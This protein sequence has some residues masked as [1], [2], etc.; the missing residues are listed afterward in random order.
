MD[1]A[2]WLRGLGLERYAQAFR[3]NDIDAEVLSRLRADDLIAIGVSSVGHRRRLLDA[4]TALSAGP[5]PASEEASVFEP[6]PGPVA[7]RAPEAERRQLTVMFVDLVG[8]T[9]ISRRLDPEAMG[10]IVR[11]Y[12]N[13]VAGE[14]GRFEGHVA[15]F[16]G[17]GVLAYFGWPRA[18]EDEAERAV[19]A[20]L[21]V[22]NA[23]AHLETPEGQA[24]AA[25]VGIATGLV[26]VGDLFD[27]A[28]AQENAA[29]GPTLALAARLQALA[30]PGS[31]VIAPG[32]RL[33]VGGLFD[34]ADLGT[35][36]VKGFEKAVRAWRVLNESPAESRF[37]ALH[38]KSL[39]PLVGREHEIGLLLER[40]E[41]A[42]D[43]EGQVVL[44]SGEPGLG[45]SRI[46][47]ALR[48]R[49]ESEAYT[50][51]SHFCSPFHVNSALYPVIA[52]LDRAAR[53]ERDDPPE[54]RLDKLEALLAQ[55][56]KSAREVAPLVAA[57]LSFPLSDRYPPLNLTP[58]AQKQRT[59]EVLVDQLAG[60]ASRQPVLAIYEDVHW[61]DPSTLDLLDLVVERVQRLRVL[62]IITFRPEFVPPWT[63]H[64]HVTSLVL[65]RLTR[66]QG[67]SMIEAVTGGKALPAEVL[68]QIVTKT[69]G[70]PL[71][72]EELTKT[73][74][75]SGPLQEAGDRYTLNGSLSYLAVPTTLHDSLLARLDRLGAAK[76][77]AQL[78]AALGREFSHELLAA[79]SPLGHAEL[80]EALAQLT[81]A[82]LLFRR[83][84]PPDATYTFKHALV[85]DA[86]YAGLLKSR[87]RQIHSRIAQ[88]LKDEFSE[89]V[90]AAPEL[91]AHHYGE[92]GLTEFAVQYWEQAGTRAL[93]RSAIIEAVAHYRTGLALFEGL[94]EGVRSERE[95]PIQIGL[96]S[97]LASAKGYANPE[98]GAAY[99]RARELCLE[100][101]EK[102]R[103][104][105]VLYG[106][107]SF[108]LVA[109]RY[110]KGKQI[111]NQFVELAKQH[112]E[113]GPLV[114]AYSALGSTFA[115]MGSWPDG[116]ENLEKCIT[117]YDPES[118]A[119]L[120]F[121]CAE[122]PCVQANLCSALCLWN[123]G[124]PDQALKVMDRA[125]NLA[126]RLQHANSKGYA[127]SVLPMLCCF[128][129]NPIETSVAAEACIKFCSETRLPGWA[130]F[131]KVWR[132]WALSHL[133]HAVEGVAELQ[134]GM[135]GWYATGGK[136]ISSGFF[137]ALGDA[138][139]MAGNYDEA[140]RAIESGLRFTE[141]HAESFR[142]AELHRL[143]GLILLNQ[144]D[145]N[146]TQTEEHFSRALGV[147][148]NQ[149]SRS[150]EL[151]ISTDLA[152]LWQR[153]GKT[154]QARELLAPIYNWFTEGFNTPA[155]KSARALLD[156]L[157]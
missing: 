64:S 139:R 126:E 62:I 45:K 145:K 127:L 77:T 154:K 33:L 82:G 107:W 113:S 27:E 133:G 6:A 14:V 50:P 151:R 90:A 87:R 104:F 5:K 85:R 11:A 141:G 89:R 8:S 103:L 43:G 78:G 96:G 72:I 53:F 9:E 157:D 26:V 102:Q 57:L 116:N 48:E 21:A 79:V 58:E 19:R 20:G 120:K 42:R 55:A 132:G 108:D 142:E 71:F 94:P 75:E 119:N 86:A 73:L 16:W 117:L 25:R 122:D 147:A 131:A 110:I 65:G 36:P 35:H 30:A 69:D 1:V 101:G 97:A 52:L 41:R 100:I 152:R 3:D 121:E 4:I 61:V 155:L 153:Q 123:L 130:T 137:A 34:L 37:E 105:P 74:I 81:T 44:L 10:E 24:L 29:V 31:V 32:T 13:T 93:E 84:S 40:F 76:E 60:L 149:Q 140:W 39:T 148:R 114:A 156:S 146:S 70:V 22:A 115:Y 38:G 7:R 135:D 136:I 63:G 129:E 54:T 92:A 49:L 68:D 67:A 138:Y 143:K 144:D 46:V 99:E 150:M 91:L 124:Y 66:R 15:N 2:A 112:G 18:H 12:Q 23:V 111:A 17:D 80:Q 59:L 51:L 118:H 56:V 134:A 28:G 106:L 128:I 47:R 98:T 83:G 95:L 88:A 125:V 109:A